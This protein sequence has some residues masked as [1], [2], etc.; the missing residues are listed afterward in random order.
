M[1]TT[2]TPPREE[3]AFPDPPDDRDY[4]P[5]WLILAPYLTQIPPLTRRQWHMLGVV[6]LA[7]IINRYAYALL[8]VAL[9]QIQ[10]G[11]GIA[12]AHLGVIGAGIQLGAVPAL[13]VFLLADRVGRRRM[14]L[15]S[16]GG[17]SLLTG[18]T[19]FAQTPAAFVVLQFSAWV[20]LIGG[21]TLGAVM[22][23]EEIDEDARGWGIGAYGALAAVGYGMSWAAFS[24]VDVLPGGWRALYAI[25][26]IGLAVLPLLHRHLPE[27]DRFK[28]VRHRNTS[29]LMPLLSLVRMYPGRFVMLGSVFILV[30]FGSYAAGFLEVKFVQET[31]GWSPVAI[32]LLALGG[33]LVGITASTQVGAL[34]DRFGRRRVTTWFAIAYPVLLMAFFNA[35]AFLLPI[36]WIGSLVAM[37]GVIV[38]LSTFTGELFPTSY[39]ST[40]AGMQA[41]MMTVG[42]IL[43]LAVESALYSASGSHAIA[44]TLMMLVMLAVPL[45]VAF[46][47]PETRGLTLE[48]IAPER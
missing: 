8:S 40:A 10:D 23:I 12:E 33:G 2:A 39:R 5:P 47:F 35:P 3:P 9:A 11:L 17:H 28:R 27:T 4:R 26:F 16:F 6:A 44:V 18:L 15:I 34:G 43:S 14:L 32:S 1:E 22:V 45:I 21:F 37:L 19:A 7:A 42:S 36:A 41:A 38:S 31:H 20:F 24:F 29:T 13:L 46:A 30:N 48:Q 25:G